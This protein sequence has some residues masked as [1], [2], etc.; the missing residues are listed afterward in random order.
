MVTNGSIYNGIQLSSF[1]SGPGDG[2]KI[3]TGLSTEDQLGYSVASAGDFNKDNVTDVVI[4]APTATVSGRSGA[5][6]VVILF[7]SSNSALDE[8]NI[9]VVVLFGYTASAFSNVVLT[10]GS[11]LPSGTAGFAIINGGGSD[12]TFFSVSGGRDL[13]GDGVSDIMIGANGYDASGTNTGRTCVLYGSSSAIGISQFFL[14]TSLS[15]YL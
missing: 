4:G 7:G 2:V 11:S 10:A 5:G 8:S 9:N 13:N 14:S 3:T 15:N 12:T 1:T 6:L